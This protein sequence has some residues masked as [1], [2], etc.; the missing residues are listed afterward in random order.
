MTILEPADGETTEDD[1][2]EPIIRRK[3][4]QVRRPVDVSES[5]SDDQPM[6]A[7]RDGQPRTG[8]FNLDAPDK[9]PVV[10]CHPVTKKMIIFTPKTDEFD[11]DHYPGQESLGQA[12]MTAAT[13]LAHPLA[14]Q[15]SNLMLAAMLS[16]HTFG[17]FLDPQGWGPAEAFFPN[18][19]GMAR[20]SDDSDMDVPQEDEEESQLRI[21]D[22][23]TWT[24]SSGDEGAEADDVWPATAESSPVR[25]TTSAS[26]VSTLGAPSIYNVAADNDGGHPLLEHFGNNADVGAFRRNQ[27]NT[28]LILSDR[29]SQDGLAFS[30]RFHIGTLRGIKSGSLAAVTTPITPARRQKRPGRMVGLD[31]A[32]QETT[33]PLSKK[34]RAADDLGDGDDLHKRHRSLSDMDMLQIQ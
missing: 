13:D 20:D 1:I 29:A 32:F 2:P 25:P 9:K 14:T 28:Q 18:M 33:S 7:R 12:L 10:V 30:S 3:E 22:F 4:K 8:K 15:P 24:D 23:I 11:D 5:D 26:G 17:Q 34:R 21:E 6:R 31:T 16:T 19:H 27:I